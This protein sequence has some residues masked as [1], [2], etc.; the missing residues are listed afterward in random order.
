M[1]LAPSSATGTLDALTDVVIANPQQG[2]ALA[3]TA[4]TQYAAGFW[5]NVSGGAGVTL[6]T[7]SQYPLDA[8]D[9]T[10]ATPAY[11]A[12]ARAAAIAAAPA[13]VASGSYPA[14]ANNV[15]AAT[16][17]YVAAARA[18]AIAAI[19]ALTVAASYPS[20]LDTTSATP[21]YVKAA[22]AATISRTT[23]NDT[24]YTVLSTDRLVAYIALTA[25]RTVTLPLTTAFP[26]GVR[27]VIMDE[28]GNVNSTNTLG[29][30][31]SGSDTVNGST[32]FTITSPYGVLELE[33]SNTGKWTII[34]RPAGTIAQQNS[35]NVALTGGT[36][37]NIA[38]GSTT[39]STGKF[40]TLQATSGLNSTAVGNTTAS[41]GAFTTLTASSG[42]NSTA[43]GN[44]TP[45][46]GAFTTLSTSALMSANLGITVAGATAKLAVGTA[47][48]GPLTFQSGVS[49]TTAA[50]G[51]WEYDGNVFYASPAASTRGAVRVEYIQAISAAYTL[52]SQ[53]AAQKLLNGTTN[54]AVT[55]PI[56]TYQFECLFS[57]TSLSA[58]SGSFGFA[59]GGTATF[60]QE[61]WADAQQTATLATPGTA[62]SSF[63]TA[64]NTS[65]TTA[66][67]NTNGFAFI[68]GIIRVTAAGTVIPQV[69]LTV[70]N[71]AVVGVNSYFKASSFGNGTV[72]SVGNWS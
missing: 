45:S 71:A 31:T 23:V 30:T 33:S 2:Q 62:Q 51:V 32:G 49:L 48:L 29:V 41:T 25:A 70:A 42:L 59:L 12:A 61:W 6:T 36:V 72:V 11:V 4:P 37:D 16:P 34:T 38:I 67:T 28:T 64:A 54:G 53:T 1:S 46:T 14:D 13:I 52:T 47:T 60:T 5:S 20:S 7:A 69:S 63:N 19:P 35:A 50:A 66:S 17:A 65:L 18:A 57:L 21:N 55:L 56:G 27:L 39:P 44:T 40:T 58:T 68:R 24:N 3:Y 9:A 8:N 15:G 26:V 22:I 43:V 10:A